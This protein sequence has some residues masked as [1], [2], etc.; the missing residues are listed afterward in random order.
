MNWNFSFSCQEVSLSCKMRYMHID[1]DIGACLNPASV[2][3]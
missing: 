3:K 1:I 2:E